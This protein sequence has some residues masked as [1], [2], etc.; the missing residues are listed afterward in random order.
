M[1]EQLPQGSYL[2]CPE[3]RH[4]A[5]WYDQQTYMEGLIYFIEAVDR[6][7]VPADRINPTPAESE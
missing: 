5:M 3:G 1:A 4:M 2:H 7:E 6:G